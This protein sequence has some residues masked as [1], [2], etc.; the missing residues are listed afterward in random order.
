MQREGIL[1]SLLGG[2][3]L[4]A[5]DPVGILVPA[6][7]I[8]LAQAVGMIAVRWAVTRGTWTMVGLLV[9]PNMLA[10]LLM[11]GRVREWSDAYFAALERGDFDS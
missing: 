8:L 1:T 3:G 5:R 7:A 4:L 10:L 2:F 11:A 9:I 6:G